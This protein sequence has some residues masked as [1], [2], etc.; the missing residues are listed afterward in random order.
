LDKRRR[1]RGVDYIRKCCSLIQFSTWKETE[2]K[3]AKEKK[4]QKIDNKKEKKKD[5]KRKRN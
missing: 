3:E 5:R 4:D 1:R 2:R